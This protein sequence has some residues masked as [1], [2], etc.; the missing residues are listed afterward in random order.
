MPDELRHMQLGEKS[1]DLQLL[2][3]K[4]CESRLQHFVEPLKADG[5]RAS[6]KVLVGTPFLEIIRE[7]RANERDL[8]MM[9]A[10]GKGG[11]S[12][13]IFG[14]TQAVH[15][16]AWTRH[17]GDSGLAMARLIQIATSSAQTHQ[18][19]APREKSICAIS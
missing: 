12:R 19:S 8:V 9:S 10:D 11:L 14:S 2:S 18:S 4:E 3:I 15:P 13:R 5:V 17:A 1:L 6:K 16:Q 7:V